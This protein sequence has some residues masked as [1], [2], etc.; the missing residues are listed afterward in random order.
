MRLELDDDQ[1][2]LQASVRALCAEHFPLE[3]TRTWTDRDS[4]DRG[5]WRTLAELGTFVMTR[6]ADE[7]GAELAT[8]DAGLVYQVLGAELV[9]GPLVAAALASDLIDEVGTGQ[10]LATVVERPA[11][12]QPAVLRH[13]GLVDVVLVLD[14]AG[15]WRVEPADVDARPVT[16]PL[17]PTT[18][19]WLATRLP[20]GERVGDAAL[21]ARWRQRG[22]VLTSALLAGIAVK[23]IEVAV[24][25][26]AQRE[27][28]GRVIGG[29]Q[30]VKHL[31]ADGFAR[32]EVARAA[33]DAAAVTIDEPGGG[34]DGTAAARAVAGARVVAARAAVANS[35][36]A[37]Q[38]HGGMGF[39]WEATPHLYLKRAWLEENVFTTPDEA[40]ELV[41]RT[42]TAGEAA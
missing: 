5:A 11:D 27:Q 38:V 34:P 30:A 41:A 6:S 10:L 23:V 39:T 28:F 18:P 32:A 22:D 42:L 2:A 16:S 9:P 1:R 21:A 14:A 19:V 15:I 25:Y 36:T 3:R 29:F 13:L 35:K 31:L 40:A 20:Q 12:G 33:V 7:G 37:I 17:D 4:F 24:A 26:A 8:V